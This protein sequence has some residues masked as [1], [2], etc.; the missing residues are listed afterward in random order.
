VGGS[1]RPDQAE[2]WLSQILALWEAGVPPDQLT[3]LA[4]IGVTSAGTSNGAVEPTVIVNDDATPLHERVKATRLARGWSQRELAEAA[5]THQPIVSKLE[6][7]R[8]VDDA[9]LARILAVLG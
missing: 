8:P 5:G 1:L 4:R 9:L 2:D 6:N 7:G 3:F